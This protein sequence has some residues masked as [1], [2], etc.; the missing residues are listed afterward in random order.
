MKTITS[1]YFTEKEFNK[2]TPTC[3]M[4]EMN[5]DTINRLD[6]ARE[7]A[8]IPFVINSGYRSPEWEKRND[9]AGTSAHTT[10][11]AVDIRCNTSMNRFVIVDALLKA[12]FKRIGI[13]KTFIHAD[14]SPVHTKNVIWVY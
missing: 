6:A 4:Q 2:C 1:K 3:S 7:I 14:D 5:Q 12:G 8:G 10:G 11:R 13:A 9:R